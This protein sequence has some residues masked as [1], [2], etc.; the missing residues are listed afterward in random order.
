MVQ[1]VGARAQRHRGVSQ[2]GGDDVI[3]IALLRKLCSRADSSP[4]RRSCA[5]EIQA[6]RTLT[7]R[8]VRSETELLVA[9]QQRAK[10]E[11]HGER[12]QRQRSRD[13]EQREAEPPAS[14]ARR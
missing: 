13:R 12:G 2:L 5:D 9:R 8:A 4:M 7:P 14:V 1:T 3:A 10:R 11:A 6:T